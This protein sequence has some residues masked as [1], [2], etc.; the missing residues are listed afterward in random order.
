MMSRRIRH[1][2]FILL[3]ASPL[4]RADIADPQAMTQQRRS[5]L[6]SRYK[7]WQALDQAEQDSI[8]QLH[9]AAQ[10]PGADGDQ[11]RSQLDR[12][13]RWLATLTSQE[14]KQIESAATSA[15]RIAQVKEILGKQTTA[16]EESMLPSRPAVAA[17]PNN[18][19]RTAG[20]KPGVFRQRFDLLANEIDRLDQIEK[21]FTEEERDRLNSASAGQKIPIII[22]LA[23]KY[24]LPLPPFVL[25]N[26]NPILQSFMALIPEAEKALG[27][28]FASALTDENRKRLGEVMVDLVLLPDLPQAKQFELLQ[29]EQVAV[30]TGIERIAKVNKTTAR[31]LT[32]LLYYSIHVDKAP[33]SCRDSLALLPPDHLRSLLSSNQFR[34]SGYRPPRPEDAHRPPRP[35]RRPPSR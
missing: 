21:T 35:D 30:R 13:D 11:L 20:R 15:E 17:A 9:Q 34:F 16:L 18:E 12:Y 25:E 1:C 6:Q 24:G 31:F 32:T 26:Q 4:L 2:L 33:P 29:S 14:R 5:M 27:T 7:D 22:A 10:Q 8:R 3:A 19:T 28:T 23:T